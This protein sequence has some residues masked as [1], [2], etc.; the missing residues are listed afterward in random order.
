VRLAV[1]VAIALGAEDGL[2]ALFPLPPA[3]GIDELLPRLT[4]RKTARARAPR[5]KRH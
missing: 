3:A 5:R 4:A 2:R 1:Q